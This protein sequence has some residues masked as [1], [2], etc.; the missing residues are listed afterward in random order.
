MSE[1]VIKLIHNSEDISNHRDKISGKMKNLRII[2]VSGFM[3][4]FYTGKNSKPSKLVPKK[5]L[6]DDF[7][8]NA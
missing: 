4:S 7:R 2:D 1:I 3:S 8:K 5:I 6:Y